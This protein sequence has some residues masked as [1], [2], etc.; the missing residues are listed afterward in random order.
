MHDLNDHERLSKKCFVQAE[1]TEARS[2]KSPTRAAS[3]AVATLRS[4][5]HRTNRA[6][7][8]P[9]PPAMLYVSLQLLCPLAAVFY[10]SERTQIFL[11]H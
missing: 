6:P 10:T 1:L 8:W 11:H 7:L 4:F 5:H 3:M 2:W 9:S